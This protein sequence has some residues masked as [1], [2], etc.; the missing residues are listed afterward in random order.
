M[1]M[2]L[3]SIGI[4][5]AFGMVAVGCNVSPPPPKDFPYTLMLSQQ[6]LPPG[7]V[8]LGGS[9]PEVEGAV[10]HLVAYSPE[11]DVSWKAIS[12]RIA[13]YPD[14]SAA[15]RAYPTWEEWFTLAM[16]AVEPGT[17]RPLSSSDEYRFEYLDV[18]ING[19]PVRSFTY[20]QRHKNMI[21]LVLVNIDNDYITLE[22]FIQVLEKLDAKLQTAE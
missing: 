19:Q 14:E 15:I 2:K 3:I 12:H 5:L 21:I 18:N 10:A 7:W 4:W 13:I 8:R 17:F 11:P 9:F 16:Q 6:D 1:K 20:L 22:E